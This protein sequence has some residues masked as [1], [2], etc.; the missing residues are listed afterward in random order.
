MAGRILTTGSQVQCPHGGQALLTTT[1]VRVKAASGEAL[2]ESD[3]HTVSGCPFTIGQKL[4]PCVRIEWEAGATRL[5]VEGTAVLLETSVGTC[6]SPENAPQ[7]AALVVQAEPK[8][9]AR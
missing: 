1:N 3:I 4:S 7:G 9:S 2:L 8:V 5:A 6:Y